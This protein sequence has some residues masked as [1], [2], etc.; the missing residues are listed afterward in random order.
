M[1]LLEIICAIP[2]LSF[3]YLVLSSEE[4]CTVHHIS[5]VV[6]NQKQNNNAK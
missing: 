3:I 2:L 1:A 5:V 6:T 4:S